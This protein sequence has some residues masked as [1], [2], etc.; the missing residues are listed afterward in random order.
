MRTAPVVLKCWCVCVFVR[1]A[2]LEVSTSGGYNDTL[3]AY[4]AGVVEAAATSQVSLQIQSEQCVRADAAS[5][6]RDVSYRCL[7]NL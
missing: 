2:Y 3:Q 7:I 5:E 6:S 1:W 4:A